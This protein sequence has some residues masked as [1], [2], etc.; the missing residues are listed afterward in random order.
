MTRSTL[1]WCGRALTLAVCLWGLVL[2]A[3]AFP[4]IDDLPAYGQNV[5][6]HGYARS[7]GESALSYIESYLDDPMNDTIRASYWSDQEIIGYKKVEFNNNANVPYYFETVDYRRSMGYQVSVRSNTATVRRIFLM[8][9]GSET[10]NRTRTVE[11]DENTVIDAG[12]H[13]FVLAN[14][15]RLLNNKTVRLQFL[16]VDK[17]RLLPLKITNSRCSIEGAACFKISLDN[18]ILQGLA[19]KVEL[20]YEKDTKR[21]LSYSGIGPITMR[22]GKGMPVEIFYEY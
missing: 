13:R 1:P 4:R 22:N 19:P 6:A 21:L 15:D 3:Q 16:Q 11:V 2:K 8:S 10:V 18:F 5:M 20:I 14:W 9:D 12:F 7:P 17:A